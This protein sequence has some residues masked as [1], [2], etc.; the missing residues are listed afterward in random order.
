MWGGPDEGSCSDDDNG[1]CC[2]DDGECGGGSGRR[3]GTGC[4]SA[5]VFSQG[6]VQLLGF[7]DFCL[8]VGS[9]EGDRGDK[10]C[11]RMGKSEFGDED[12]GVEGSGNGV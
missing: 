4:V 12:P 7:P 10:E 11:G 1:A 5:L 9:D 8:L 2:R 6:P 3:V